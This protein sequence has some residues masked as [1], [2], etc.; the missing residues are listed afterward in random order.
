MEGGDK[1]SLLISK[2]CND[3]L[4]HWFCMIS[5]LPANISL[6]AD[7]L[8]NDDNELNGVGWLSNLLFYHYYHFYYYLYSHYSHYSNYGHS[9]HSHHSRNSRYSHHSRHFMVIL[10]SLFAFFHYFQD[11]NMISYNPS[12][13]ELTEEEDDGQGKGFEPIVLI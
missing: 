12:L 2:T 13:F 9:Y 3:G 8:L 10:R 7:G 11:Q 6:S 4:L 1:L 5:N